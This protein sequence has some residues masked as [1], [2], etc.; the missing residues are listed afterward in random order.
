MN[1]IVKVLYRL[2]VLILSCLVISSC[3]KDTDAS[4]KPQIVSGAG[5]ITASVNRFRNLLGEPLNVVPGSTGGRREINWDGVPDK[6]ISASIPKTF[7]NATGTGDPDSR[8]RGFAYASDGDFRISNAGF[9]NIEQTLAEQLGAF[10][11]AKIFANISSDIWHTGFQVAGEN[12]AAAVNGFGAVFIDVDVANVSALEYFSG[13]VSL[14]KFFVP[15]HDQKTNLSFLGVYFNNPIVTKVQITHG[16]GVIIPGQK[17]ISNGGTTDIVAMDD[18]LYS[19][20]V[21][22]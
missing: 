15:P 14:G 9:S 11:G 7:F 21:A 18:F 8:K 4:P 16:N 1:T 10:S 3:K 6:Y 2:S 5:D 17:D 19:E 12:K 20:P 13:D 22:K